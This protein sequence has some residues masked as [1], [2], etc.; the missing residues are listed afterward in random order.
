MQDCN[1][2][3]ALKFF[4]DSVHPMLKD[5]E[6]MSQISKNV[7]DEAASLNFSHEMMA[8]YARSMATTIKLLECRLG[9][10]LSTIFNILSKSHPSEVLTHLTKKEVGAIAIGD[11]MEL[12]SCH[13]FS[14][15]VLPKMIYKGRFVSRPLISFMLR[16]STQIGQIYP[17][18][19]AY[20]KV[21]FFEEYSPLQQA[22][23]FIS[24]QFFYFQNYTLT[25]VSDKHVT[26]LYP[27]LEGKSV[28][29]P[30][31][32]FQHLFRDRPREESIS[33][34]FGN[35]ISIVQ[36]NKMIAERMQLFFTDSG[37]APVTAS[38]VKIDHL[39][40]TSVSSYLAYVQNPFLILFFFIC[41][42]LNHF[43]GIV[44][45]AFLIRHVYITKCKRGSKVGSP[46]QPALPTERRLPS[47]PV[48]QPTRDRRGDESSRY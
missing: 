36:Q 43:W 41:Q 35:I 13:N 17:D 21:G 48:R 24:G 42:I 37:S 3:S 38:D 28:T 34:D 20:I 22:T 47:R 9:S 18:T 6:V 8:M 44:L 14:A 23:F 10:A 30:D 31:V 25:K 11:T 4:K 19:K 32:D 27:Q 1:A 7:G 39:T 2:S 45:T 26:S 5:A 46:L 12:L 33:N 15:N 16:N 29:I 40:R